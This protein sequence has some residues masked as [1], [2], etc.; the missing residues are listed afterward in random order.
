MRALQVFFFV[1]LS[2]VPV[3]ASAQAAQDAKKAAS[4]QET[5]P[6]ASKESAP[7]EQLQQAIDRAG[8]DRA[9]LVRNL[10]GYLKLFPDTKR[11]PEIYRALVEADLQ[12]K[13][14]GGA[15]NYAERIVA[16]SPEDMSMTLVAIQLLERAGNEDGLKRATSYAARVLDYVQRESSAEKSPRVSQQEWEAERRKS[17][18]TILL[19]RGR[20]YLRQHDTANA[21]RDFEESYALV[22]NSTAAEKLGELAELQKDLPRAI[23]QY[24]RAFALSDSASGDDNRPGIR[25]KLGNVWRLAHGSEDGLGEFLLKTYDETSRAVR[26]AADAKRNSDSPELY[27]FKLRQIPDGP[28]LSLETARG[29]VIVLNFWATW[30]GPCRAIEPQFERVAAEFRGNDA[31]LFLAVNCDEDETLVPPYIQEEKMR[32]TVV[33]ADGLGRLLAVN[34]YPTVIVL[35]K[36]G[37]ISYRAVGFGEED[38]EINLSAA[39][40]EAVCPPG[41][42]Q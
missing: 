24:A 22:P 37:K 20:L 15:A 4:P 31:V 41:A 39:I 19:L 16:L 33:F 25:R 35:D 38:F 9:A 17:R 27:D 26:P 10:E 3:P 34:S 11:K 40:G 5:K 36:A 14:T 23:A 6:A 29:K 28:P 1:A 18:M 12:L 7:D 13:D 21:S 2:A 42:V 32:A 30:C 8:N